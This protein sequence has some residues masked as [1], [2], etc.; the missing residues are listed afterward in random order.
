MARPHD[1]ASK[2]ELLIVDDTLE[3]LRLLSRMLAEEGYRVETASSGA[4]ALATAQA[5]PPDL[6]LLDIKMPEMDGYEVCAALKADERTRDIPIIFLSALDETY[7]K[8]KAF[9]SGGVDYI[10]KPFQFEEVLAR[11]ETHIALMNLQRQLQQANRELQ[12][13]LEELDAFAHTVAHDLKN[14]LTRIIGYAELLEGEFDTLPEED[15]RG[16]LGVIARG[17]RKMENIINELLLLA[18]VR[19]GEVESQPLDM[20]DIV[21]EVQR[22][23]GHVI[24]GSQAQI[25]EPESWPAALGHGPWIEEVWLNY[26]S[27]AIKYSGR[28][29]RLELGGAVEPGGAARFW[30]RDNGP[31]LSEEDQGRL[32]APF[33]RLHQ[34]RAE[35]H[36]LGLSIV[37]RIVDKLGGQVGVESQVGKGS[38]FYFTLPSVGVTE[39]D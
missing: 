6:V 29:P 23:L 38:V 8:V 24:E 19:E 21:N 27:N 3:N 34:V 31:G 18:S 33:T 32:F 14:P 20:S 30:V 11:V 5:N 36:G 22:R 35:G 26:I 13:R 10:I 4:R 9:T 16:F 1:D 25:I 37:R 39:A 15:L 7:D 12:K 2:A 17:G 28:E